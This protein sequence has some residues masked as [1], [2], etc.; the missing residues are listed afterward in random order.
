MGL[1]F[2]SRDVHFYKTKGVGC[3]PALHL[4]PWTPY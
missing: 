4:S 3:E 1:S 2:A